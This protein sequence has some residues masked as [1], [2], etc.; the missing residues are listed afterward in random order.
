MLTRISLPPI[1]FIVTLW[2]L[3]C[4]NQP[5]AATRPADT[6]P[7]VSLEAMNVGTALDTFVS[8]FLRRHP[9]IGN[10]DVTLENAR[11][12]FA[13]DFYKNLRSGFL[14]DMPFT[15]MALQKDVVTKKITAGFSVR[16]VSR[17]SSYA[18]VLWVNTPISE[19]SGAKLK[20]FVDYRIQGTVARPKNKRDAKYD[21]D[22]DEIYFEKKYLNNSQSPAVC[23]L[24]TVY[25]LTVDLK[26]FAEFEQ[27]KKQ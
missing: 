19:E 24:I 26:S 20:E 23:I 21:S 12:D 17:D 3:A 14:K 13:K 7:S 22:P 1:A 2:V 18:A 5:K 4:N 6:T 15:S 9:D 27:P 25:D 11:K 10:D 16:A 8:A